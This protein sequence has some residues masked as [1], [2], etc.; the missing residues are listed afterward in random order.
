MGITRIY[1]LLLNKLL[2]KNVHFKLKH[3]KV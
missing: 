3:L 2:I 1:I